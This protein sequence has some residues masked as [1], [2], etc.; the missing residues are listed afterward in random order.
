MQ[1]TLRLWAQS[2]VTESDCPMV[3]SD[4]MHSQVTSEP[5]KCQNKFLLQEQNQT[6][7]F[8]QQFSVMKIK[9]ISTQSPE[10]Q[11]KQPKSKIG[12]TSSM[13]KLQWGDSESQQDKIPQKCN[14][15]GFCVMNKMKMKP[16]QELTITAREQSPCKCEAPS[17]ASAVIT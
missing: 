16:E 11:Q 7:K 17:Q 14:C 2:T 9:N 1:L 3:R 4:R 10:K 13:K 5:I 6:T 15:P 8:N 12:P